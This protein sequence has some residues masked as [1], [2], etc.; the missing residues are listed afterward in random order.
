MSP[1]YII[2]LVVTSIVAVIMLGIGI[3]QLKSKTPVGF[4]SGEQPPSAD[5]L[6]DVPSWNKKHGMMWIIYGVVIIVSHML[7]AIIDYDV[8]FAVFF[9]SALIV[10]I[11]FM[12]WYHHRLTK[13]YK[14]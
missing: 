9:C 12:C 5:E 4:Y 7:G 11:I 10:P 3:S 6:S 2:S 8:W 1:E 14:R 13:I